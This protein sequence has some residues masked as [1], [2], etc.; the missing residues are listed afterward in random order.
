M[1]NAHTRLSHALDICTVDDSSTVNEIS[2]INIDDFEVTMIPALDGSPAS[3]G[4]I[5]KQTTV[6]KP[7]LADSHLILD[8]SSTQGLERLLEAIVSVKIYEQMGVTEHDE[9]LDALIRRGLK[10]S[11]ITLENIF[12]TVVNKA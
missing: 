8:V 1:T 4:L 6:S 5:H 3:I 2:M 9:S 12:T 11:N 10:A 7:T